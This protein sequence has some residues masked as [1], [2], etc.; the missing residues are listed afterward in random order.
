MIHLVPVSWYNHGYY[1][2]N[3]LLF[4]EI[5][6]VNN[7]QLLAEGFYCNPN[8]LSQVAQGI[9]VNNI[10]PDEPGMTYIT[11]DGEYTKE[12]ERISNSYNK[13]VFPS[14]LVYMVA[15]KKNNTSAFIYPV[16]T[17]V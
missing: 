13:T 15:L 1:N 8:V 14:N 12:N 7:Y 4:K 9:P 16:D 11:F 2:F 10:N 3:P 5:A 6:I 17:Q